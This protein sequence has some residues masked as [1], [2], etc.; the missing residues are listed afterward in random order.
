[1]LISYILYYVSLVQIIT[2]YRPTFVAFST[3]NRPN[4]LPSHYIELSKVMENYNFNRLYMYKSNFNAT[5][6]LYN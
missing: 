3:F 4:I 1:M 2:L 6:Y 5:N